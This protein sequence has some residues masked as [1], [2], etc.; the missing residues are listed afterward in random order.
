LWHICDQ[1]TSNER[2][3]S[4]RWQNYLPMHSHIPLV[5]L[6]HQRSSLSRKPRKRWVPSRLLS[7]TS[8]TRKR[9]KRKRKELK[10]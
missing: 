1:Y 4:L 3:T 6:V 7:K 9:K 5:W 8:L 10:R 2:R